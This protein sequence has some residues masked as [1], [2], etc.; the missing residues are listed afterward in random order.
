GDRVT[1][2]SNNVLPHFFGLYDRAQLLIEP[3]DDGARSAGRRRQPRSIAAPRSRAARTRRLW[4]RQQE[5]PSAWEPPPLSHANVPPRC[6]RSAGGIV[7]KPTAT[8]PPTR[9]LVSGPVPL[10]DTIVISALAIALNS[11]RWRVGSLT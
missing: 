4:E 5:R 9:S 3:L 8:W 11:S 7:L 1:S 10:Y 6:C 2:L